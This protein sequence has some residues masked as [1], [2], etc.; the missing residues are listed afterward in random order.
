MFV[1]APSNHPSS[2]APHQ[3][4]CPRG[5]FVS[6]ASMAAAASAT[7]QGPC[8]D[9][10]S[11][12]CDTKKACVREDNKTVAASNC[13]K[14]SVTETAPK[15]TS[16]DTNTNK[17]R[18]HVITERSPVHRN[19]TDKVATI[20]IDVTGYNVEDLKI[21]VDDDHIVT[22]NGRRK[23]KLGDTYVIHRRFKLDKNTA[24]KDK[25]EIRLVDGILDIV[26]PKK[27]VTGPR[28]IPITTTTTSSYS[29]F[30][31]ASVVEKEK[32]EKHD[33]DKE[34]QEEDEQ[35]KTASEEES[36]VTT[37][38][39]EEDEDDESSK[40]NSDSSKN[41]EAWEDVTESA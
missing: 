25:I 27:S 1:V 18:T 24:D 2:F 17:N 21:S 19:E 31:G 32:E 40:H 11:N 34:T 6:P 41:D 22:V 4:G 26:V 7:A 20:S 37:V 15:S 35:T 14:K 28:L 10:K 39:E 29:I 16:T 36:G 5:F 8:Q 30:L 38:Q 23:N 33:S 9:K 3:G 13:H 12:C